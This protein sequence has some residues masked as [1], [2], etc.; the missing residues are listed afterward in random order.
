MRRLAVMALVIFSFAASA[1]AQVTAAVAANLQFAF[2]DLRAEFRKSTGIDVKA[3][4]GASG[5]L[6]TQIRNGAPFDVFISA[7]VDY[8]DTLWK[9]RHAVTPPRIYAYGELVLW[10]AKDVD[11]SKGPELVK[12]P[13]IKRVGIG[14]PKVTV[15]GPAAIEVLKKLGVYEAA[16]SKIV[17]GEN[18]SQVGQYVVTGAVDIGFAPL[19][20]AGSNAMRGRGRFVLVDPKL[21]DPL[22]QA[23]V[24]TRYGKDNNPVGSAKLMEF[25]FSPKAREI[26]KRYGYHLP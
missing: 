7:D 14:D 25:L 6:S 18:I 2:E 3:V 1:S 24:V 23:V 13:S 16:R 4:Y 12:E 15:Y 11:L 21:Y 22:P 20:I 17:Y 8:P 26:F 9:H 5:K 19:S 10:T